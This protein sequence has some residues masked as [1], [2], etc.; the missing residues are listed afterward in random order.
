M[1]RA[2]TATTTVRAVGVVHRLRRFGLLPKL[3][4]VLAR[5][6]ARLAIPEVREAD[7]VTPVDTECGQMAETDHLVRTGRG[8]GAMNDGRPRGHSRSCAL[9]WPWTLTLALVAVTAVGCGGDG[10]GTAARSASTTP[11]S[12]SPPTALSASPSM[13]VRA[14]VLGQYE[15]FWAHLPEAAAAPASQRRQILLPFAADPELTSLLRGMA[16][17]DQRD[18]VIYGRNQPR[19]KIQTLSEA[20]GLA[21]ISDCQDSSHS[22]VER[23]SDHEKLTVGVARNPV[24]TTMKLSSDGQWRISFVSYPKTSC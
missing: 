5:R 16:T 22:G 23:R 12:L 20:Q 8:G 1:D 14:Q 17:Q 6:S 2:R 13:D 15:A 10:Q 3:V 9:T 24:V 21:V 11:A 18:E 7:R 4:A 19:A